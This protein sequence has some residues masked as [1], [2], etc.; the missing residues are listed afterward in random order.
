MEIPAKNIVSDETFCIWKG[1]ILNSVENS[2]P[3]VHWKSHNCGPRVDVVGGVGV[4]EQKISCLSTRVFS[5]SSN[6]GQS[7]LRVIMPMLLMLN[8]ITM[9][10]NAR[11]DSNIVTVTS[12]RWE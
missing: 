1:C 8:S 2:Q 4:A 6:N 10:K 7:V 9:T 3:F 12:H 11:L 5:T